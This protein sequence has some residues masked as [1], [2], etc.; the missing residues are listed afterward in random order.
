MLKLLTMGYAYAHFHGLEIFRAKG[1]SCYVFVHFRTPAEVLLNNAW[2][3]SKDMCILFPPGVAHFYRS[4]GK[5]YVND[6][7]HF[8]DP[9]G[10][11][12]QTGLPTGKLFL[13]GNAA[14]IKR[15][16]QNLSES[17]HPDAPWQ[18]EALDAELRG[19]LYRL[20]A[21]ACRQEGAP[22][23]S[24]HTKT[25]ANVRTRLYGQP[26][27][28]ATIAELAK[29]AGMSVSYFQ[30]L[31]KKQYGVSVGEDII[32]GRLDRACFLLLNSNYPV[33]EIAY[34]C[35]YASDA[36]FSRQFKKMVGMSPGCYRR[37]NR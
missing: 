25:L 34:M 19:L 7:I 3:P 27:P 5:E 16:I 17:M 36:H 4:I 1:P 6:W 9:D 2:V 21:E 8:D 10:F 15:A 26:R 20:A 22:V 13:P 37:H 29:E 32:R 18:K 23:P 35:G 31:Y 12:K 11:V 28:M 14:Y 24:G 30:A 33:I